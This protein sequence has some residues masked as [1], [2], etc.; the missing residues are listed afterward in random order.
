MPSLLLQLADFFLSKG[1]ETKPPEWLSA[2]SAYAHRGL[3]SSE[4]A[5]NSSSAFA[6]AIAQGFGIEC[7][8]RLS[9]D[10]R[11]IVFHDADLERLTGRPGALDRMTV[12][13]IVTRHLTVGAEAIPTLHDV[14]QQV[15]SQVPLLLEI[16][17]DQGQSIAP[18]C[19]AV[20]RDLEGYQGK[21][22]VMS[23]E[24]RVGKW[25]AQHAA[26]VT[27]GLVV[28]ESGAR[29]AL[30]ELKR[31]FYLRK[32]RAQFLAYDIRDLPSTFAERQRARGLPILTWTVSSPELIK[33]AAVC[34][35]VP[36]AE[37]KGLALET[38]RP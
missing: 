35:D 15:A 34:A 17:V 16:K 37:G 13:E 7:D 14:L 31:H 8:V 32:S 11:A 5:E 30:D 18:I 6:D 27:R 36:I 38:M 22:A 12:G 2:T 23:F 25:F 24:P 4:I 33:R 26:R 3:H 20:R 21:V 19:R 9:A 10:G 29:G 28:T 1:G